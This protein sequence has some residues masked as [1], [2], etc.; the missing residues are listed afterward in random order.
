[1]IVSKIILRIKE[2]EAIGE[3]AKNDEGLQRGVE[4]GGVGEEKVKRVR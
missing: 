2:E 1:M 3:E 4:D